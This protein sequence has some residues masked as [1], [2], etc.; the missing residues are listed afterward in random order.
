VLAAG[1]IFA[2]WLGGWIHGMIAEST[3]A[4]H[5]SGEHHATLL[6]MDLHLA[7]MLISSL[8]AI[9]GIA[10]A[11]YFHL[12]NRPAA[13][14]MKD[15]HQQICTLL[16]NKYYIDEI[17]DAIIVRPL[18][19]IGYAC[20]V[21]DQLVIDGIVQFVGFVPRAMGLTVQPAQRGVLQGYGVG[22][23]TGIMVLVLIVLMV[24]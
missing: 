8:I 15:K 17:Y 4:V 3:A 13:D 6:G 22:M 12:L 14:R 21:I 23:L 24:M 7:M 5:P 19:T 16:E 9:V 20:F 18:R 11:A 1:A 10:I 2:G